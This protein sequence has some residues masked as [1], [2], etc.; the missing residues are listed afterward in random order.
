MSLSPIRLLYVL[1]ACVEAY[2]YLTHKKLPGDLG[3]L[4]PSMLDCATMSY[5]FSGRKARE[6]LG[7]APLY[8]LDE[9]VHRTVGQWLKLYAK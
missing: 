9:A 8:T 5:T 1:G 2:A 6:V 3:K 7:Y 4:T